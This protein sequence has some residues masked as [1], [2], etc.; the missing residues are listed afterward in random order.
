MEIYYKGFDMNPVMS[1][2]VP[3]IYF[4][5]FAVCVLKNQE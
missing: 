3:I 1:V 4:G 2:E 5:I